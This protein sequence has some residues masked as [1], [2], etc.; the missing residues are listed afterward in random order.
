MEVLIGL[1]SPIIVALGMLLVSEK[2]TE[3]FY[4]EQR[5]KYIE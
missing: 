5:S 3:T 1:L 4:D 2:E